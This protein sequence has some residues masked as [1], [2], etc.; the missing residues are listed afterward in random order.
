MGILL[1]IDEDTETVNVSDRF[2]ITDQPL[3]PCY[4]PS[5]LILGLYLWKNKVISFFITEGLFSV[6]CTWCNTI[7]MDLFTTVYSNS[8]YTHTHSLSV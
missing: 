6:L 7:I 4:K 3:I 5:P 8:V 2:F 1:F